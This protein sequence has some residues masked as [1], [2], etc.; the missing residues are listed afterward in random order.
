MLCARSHTIFILFILPHEGHPFDSEYSPPVDTCQQNRCPEGLPLQDSS[1]LMSYCGYF[2][3]GISNTAL[4]YGGF[5]DQTSPREDL[6]SWLEN[7]VLMESPISTEAQRISH[8]IWTKLSAKEQCIRIRDPLN[9]EQWENLEPTKSPSPSQVPS[10]SLSPTVSPMPT[11]FP[12]LTIKPTLSYPP[13][14]QPSSHPTIHPSA[15]PSASPSNYPTAHPSFSPTTNPSDMPSSNPSKGLHSISP[16]KQCDSGCTRTNGYMFN[17]KLGAN[18]ANDIKIFNVSFRHKEAS[19]HRIVRVHTVKEG[20][21]GNEESMESWTEIA[22]DRV[23]KRNNIV[24]TIT[25]DPQV[26]IKAGETVGFWLTSEENILIAGKFGKTETIDDNSVKLQYGMAAVNGQ[27]APN[28]L[29]SG[30][31]EYEIVDN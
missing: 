29:W 16:L 19:V 27:F 6:S 22:S 18:A 25:L 31:V 26:R 11:S 4:T 23:P 13:T 30:S 21:E 8:L 24:S 14:S 17:V 10:S 12:T 28:Y 1:T 2:C 20:Y 9:V 3:G 7:P 5:W 15:S